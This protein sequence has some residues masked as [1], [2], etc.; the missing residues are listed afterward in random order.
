[1]S[2]FDENLQR[3][4]ELAVR[5]GVGLRA[6]QRLAVRAPVEGAP[7]VRL[8]VQCA[9]EHGARFVDVLWDDDAITLARFVHAPRDS[10]EEYPDWQVQAVMDADAILIVHATDPDLLSEQDAGLVALTRRVDA[11]KRQPVMRRVQANEM[12][13]CVISLPIPSWAATVFPDDADAVPRLWDVIFRACRADRPDAVEAWQRHLESLQC[14]REYLT[15]KHYTALRYAGS[16]TD[17]TLGL[18]ERHIWH[19]GASHTPD[20]ITF[21]PNIPTEEVYTTPHRG[22]A[23]GVVASTKPL[24]YAGVLIEDIM[25]RFEDGRIVEVKA[26]TGEDVLRKLFETDDGAS[27]LGEVAL[28]P[29]S[30]PISQS[31]VLFNNTLFDENA[32][33]HLAVGRAYR[34]CVEG[35]TQMSDEEFVAAGGND[36][37]THVDFMIG[38][39]DM[40]IDG[41]TASGGAEPV[42]R[43]GEWAFDV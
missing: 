4:A 16:G 24:S 34:Y 28:V 3:Y 17:F 26:R 6:G 9:Y 5:V 19:G 15:A 37:L 25:L 43:S 27:R 7:L 41:I 35:G 38:S 11:T 29:H 36:S 22:R 39:G 40:D 30:S 1:M 18:P 23:D 10:F 21:I 8:I 31:G 14:R 32:S 2:S 20:G 42:M 33:S 13:W 12:N